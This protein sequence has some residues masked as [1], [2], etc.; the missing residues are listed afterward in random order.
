[1]GPS[2]TS[3]V[4]AKEPIGIRLAGLDGLRAVAVIVVVLFHGGVLPFGWVGVNL[5]FCLSG[6][7]I[8]GILLDAKATGAS[9]NSIL[10]PFYVRRALRILPLA[11][12]AA[13]IV[14]LVTNAGWSTLWY[15][16][17]LVN[18]KPWPPPPRELGHYWTL[19]VEEQYYMLWPIVVL[20]LSPSRLIKTAASLLVLCSVARA[21]LIYWAPTFATPHFLGNAT[22]TRADPILIGSA[23]ALITRDGIGNFL[24]YKET[25]YWVASLGLL[26]AAVFEWLRKDSSPDWS[27]KAAYVFIE[28]SL[29]LGLGAILLLVLLQ[30]PKWL[31]WGWLENLGRVSYGIYVIHGCISPWLRAN[32]ADPLMRT[33]VLLSLSIVLASLSWKLFESPIL[34]FKDRWPMPQR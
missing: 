3:N 27:S 13:L 26:T 18:W 31:Q 33:V 17:Y 32:I 6:F 15:V 25:A 9:T 29:A 21:I 11:M 30:P 10:V 24:R 14:A 20:L 34:S 1:M 2:S 7:L 23:L 19:A 12:L 22:I 8:T 4:E 28:P 16:T 5:F